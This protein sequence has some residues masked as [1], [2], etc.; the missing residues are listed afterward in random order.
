MKTNIRYLIEFLAK[1]DDVLTS[2]PYRCMIELL[3]TFELYLPSKYT[4][5]QITQLMQR[6]NMCVPAS[7]EE[8]V[9]L[10][11]AYMEEHLPATLFDA[12]KTLFMTLLH[13]NFP[14]KKGFLAHSL[15]L[16]V[17]QLEPVEKSIYEN[18]LAYVTGLNRALSFFSVLGAKESQ[19]FSPEVMVR[20]AEAM[21]VYLISVLFNDEEKALMEKG[22]RELLG[23]YLSLYGRYLYTH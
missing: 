1:Q 16:F 21:H 17:S 13:A 10:F 2:S 20:Y 23:V 3:E 7:C 12:R 22:L 18:L 15:E 8:G 5:T 6:S 9:T 19:R 4:A 14:K 11:D